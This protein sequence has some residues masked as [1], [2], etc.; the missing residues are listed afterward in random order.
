MTAPANTPSTAVATVPERNRRVAEAKELNAMVVAIR[1]TQWGNECSPQV[2]RAVAHYC[3][4]NGLD[5]VRHVEV[6]GGR[7]Y[8]TGELYEE[9]GSPLVLSGAVVLAEPDFVHEDKRLAEQAKSENA[10]LATWATGE[11]VRRIQQRIMLGI[12]DDATGACVYR[13]TVAGSVLVGF[14]WCGG[15]SKAKRKKD[16]TT[17][18]ADPVG[19]AEPVK[20]AQSRAKRRMW[21]QI[22]QAIPELTGTMGALEAT[23]RVINAEL[24]TIATAEAEQ[25]GDI[26]A[27]TPSHPTPLLN[28]GDGYTVTEMPEPGRTAE[29]EAFEMELADEKPARVRPEEA[30][31]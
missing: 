31:A 13:A 12:P 22:V 2:Q 24:T 20:T 19:D 7:I 23:A 9:R 21:R 18:R 15:A 28:T 5:A 3:N 25:G 4:Q 1:G 11:Q 14:N 16:G 30:S 29:E 8:L 10:T 17:Y 26:K 27:G 6:L